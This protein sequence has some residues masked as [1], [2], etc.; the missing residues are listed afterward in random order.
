MNAVDCPSTL[1]EQ[2]C[3]HKAH[4]TKERFVST[5]KS[6]FFVYGGYFFR[7]IQLLILVPFYGRVLGAAEYGKV[8]AAMSLFQVVCVIVEYG[9]PIVGA[10][11]LASTR[12]KAMIAREFG[13]QFAARL[14]M[15][16]L[17]IAVG[18]GGTAFS[19][20]LRADPALGL[21][22]TALG[23]IS[24][25]N[26]SWYF[27]G[28][29]RFRTSVTLEVAGFVISLVLV[30]SVVR[31]ASDGLLVLMS[32]LAAALACAVAAYVI[33]LRQIDI[34]SIRFF[35]A[36]S[37]F[38]TSTTL[39]TYKGLSMIVAGASTYLLSLFASAAEVG[40]YGSADRLANVA[41]SLMQPANQVL[42]GTVTW[43]LGSSETEA[44]A[45]AL[46]RKGLAV[47]GTFGIAAFLGAL[48][49]SPY[50]IPI[51]FGPGFDNSI[52]IMQLFGLMFPF[53][54]LGQVVCMYILIPL[55][56]DR[57]VTKITAVGA[58]CSLLAMLL[59]VRDFNGLGVA[60]ARVIGAVVTAILLATAM[61]RGA[62]YRRVFQS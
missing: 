23:I 54:A 29:L 19:P 51:I 39:F 11:D 60:G 35:G 62:L 47:I 3:Q 13:R 46:M 28:T 32:L 36:A 38:R 20:V 18:V 5:K 43:R 10:R 33:A 12:D 30:L 22:A 7:Y 49:L 61:V 59:L 41:L 42:I 27:Q 44:A 16:V 4:T 37:L 24:A 48:T 53:A 56:E 21:V 31:G 55:R 17:G 45:Y 52:P 6:L 25:F 57:L 34:R 40:Y 2:D 58:V 9:F 14:V 15:S 1:Q 50:L 8:L 26:L